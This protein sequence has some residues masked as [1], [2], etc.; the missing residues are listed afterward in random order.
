MNLT[1]R[2]N[3]RTSKSRSRKGCARDGGNWFTCANSLF[4]RQCVSSRGVPRPSRQDPHGVGFKHRFLGLY[5]I[6]H[7]LLVLILEEKVGAAR[8]IVTGKHVVGANVFRSVDVLFDDAQPLFLEP[9][10]TDRTQRE[11]LAPAGGGDALGIGRG[12]GSRG[13]GSGLGGGDAHNRRLDIAIEHGGAGQSEDD[14]A[15]N[16]GT[17]AKSPKITSPVRDGG[18]LNP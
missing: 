11:A 10:I 12:G 15:D 4:G 18:I 9:A 6:R 3:S 17:A 13:V 14:Q 7:G 2:P 5:L 16:K 8:V 1:M